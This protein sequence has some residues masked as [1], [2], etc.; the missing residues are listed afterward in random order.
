MNWERVRLTSNVTVTELPADTELGAEIP[1][2]RAA[3]VQ[4]RARMVE[5]D[6]TRMIERDS[7]R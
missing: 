4:A 6:E 5:R 1:V 3:A 7:T 2:I